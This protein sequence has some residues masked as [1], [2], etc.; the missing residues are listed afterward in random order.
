MVETAGPIPDGALEQFLAGITIEEGHL[1]RAKRAV[2]KSAS[3]RRS[4]L[5]IVLCEGKKREVR[6]MC[7]AA[8]IS[9][10]RLIRTRFGPVRLGTLA[11]GKSRQLS[12]EEVAALKETVSRAK[13]PLP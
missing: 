4:V 13:K 7:R 2:V 9:V 3:T 10:E 6:Q 12:A 11:A 1:A 8:G 5:E